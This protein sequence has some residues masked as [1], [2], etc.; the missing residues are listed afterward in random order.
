[1]KKVVSLLLSFSLCSAFFSPALA[2]EP[3]D[4]AEPNI[5]MVSV[6]SAIPFERSLEYEISVSRV[7][8]HLKDLWNMKFLLIY[9]HI[10]I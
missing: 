7:Q 9:N 2:V 10:P 5:S 4:F 6:E 8:S 3:E 1:M